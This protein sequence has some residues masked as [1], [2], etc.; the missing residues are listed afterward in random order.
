MSFNVTCQYCRRQVPF[1]ATRCPYCTGELLMGGWAAKDR[2][3]TKQS[4]SPEPSPEKIR[5][6][7]WFLLLLAAIFGGMFAVVPYGRIL[8]K[9]WDVKVM[10]ASIGVNIGMLVISSLLKADDED[11]GLRLREAWLDCLKIACGVGVGGIVLFAVLSSLFLPESWKEVSMLIGSYLTLIITGIGIYLRLAPSSGNSQPAQETSG[12][13][14]PELQGEE[15]KAPANC[16]ELDKIQ[17]RLE[18]ENKAA[19]E[20]QVT[21]KAAAKH[22]SEEAARVVTRKGIKFIIVALGTFFLGYTLH[23]T[24]SKIFTIISNGAQTTVQEP[25]AQLA[26]PKPTPIQQ[27]SQIQQPIPIQQPETTT[28]TPIQE[29]TPL[30]SPSKESSAEQQ[31]KPEPSPSQVPITSAPA[32]GFDC[33]KARILAEV[34]ICANP[35]LAEADAKLSQLYKEAML[36]APSP[37]I[38]TRIRSEQQI[39]LA[40]YRNRCDTVV[41]LH[42]AYKNRI[43]VLAELVATQR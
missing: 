31:A 20:R 4:E 41:C 28:P 27:P 40:G 26:T 39:W 8:P 14:A 11:N 12:A 3:S 38:G 22:A 19:L 30:P 23:G 16:D 33:T 43:S 24:A 13:A 7:G 10:F 5:V 29:A 25:Q 2:W 15:E 18:A 34:V 32:P 9:D 42:E 21:E 17:I 35:D 36:N 37:E 1:E 6:Q